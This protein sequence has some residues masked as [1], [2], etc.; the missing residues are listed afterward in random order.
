[1]PRSSDHE[2]RRT[3]IAT[4]FQRL[5]AEEGPTAT[6]LARVAREAQVSVGSIQHYFA[7]RQALLHFSYTSNAEAV[8]QRVQVRVEQGERDRE[9]IATMTLAGLGQL[10]PLDEMRRTEMA[11][12]RQLL[13]EAPF[14]P[15]LAKVAQNVSHAL[16]ERLALGIANGKKCGEVDSSTDPDAAATTLL[17]TTQGLGL[18]LDTSGRIVRPEDVSDVLQPVAA[19]IFSGP[20]R[21]HDADPTPRGVQP[22][23]LAKSADE[24]DT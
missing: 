15:D 7:D 22:T 14:N 19:N 9:S 17:A 3:L 24:R 8:V 11:V 23:P 18:V 16:L 5:L 6:S 4:A 2:E 10:L 12:H 13:A 20:C 21:H 1:M